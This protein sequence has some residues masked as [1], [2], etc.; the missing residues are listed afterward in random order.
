MTSP[1]NDDLNSLDSLA[2][3]NAAAITADATSNGS[4]GD[5]FT[6]A[7]IPF[8]SS[9]ISLGNSYT[10]T[11]SNTYAQMLNLAPTDTGWGVGTFNTYLATYQY[12]YKTFT[13]WSDFEQGFY[14][15]VQQRATLQGVNITGMDQAALYK[16]FAQD[17]ATVF[18]I[19]IN[20]DGTLD[21]TTGDWSVLT[22]NSSSAL[23]D[24][25]NPNNPFILAFN[26]FVNTM[27]PSDYPKSTLPSNTNFA[28]MSSFMASFQTFLTTNTS[29]NPAVSTLA[30]L[31]TGAAAI[32]STAPN[33]TAFDNVGTYEQIYNA[34][35]KNPTPA[36]F[37][38]FINAFYN[39]EIKLKG[40]FTPGD[41]ATDFLNAAQNND[42]LNVQLDEM[43]GSSISGTGSEALLVL[44]RVLELLI[45]LVQSLQN[46]GIVQA[47]RLTYYTNFQN[48]Y[49]GMISEVPV[50][51][52]GQQLT[53]INPNGTTSQFASPIGKT[54]S[55]STDAGNARNDINSAFNGLMTDNIRSLRDIQENN[56]KQ[57]QSNINTTNDAVNQ[58]TD[59]VSTFLQQ[60]STMLSSILK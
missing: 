49:T 27:T 47:Q 23:F 30:L 44:N 22:Q 19:Q 38:T 17:F 56:A 39:N 11:P 60:L 5:G 37:S 16:G 28:D 55:K 51:T 21:G 7:D 2:A 13:N 9:A 57:L 10:A 31:Q 29:T 1:I 50:F 58:Q 48:A 46:V 33:Q 8:S 41:S 42:P 20:S 25:S 54:G 45:K 6:L 26:Q 53:R 36:G 40:Y 24:E 35:A 15:Y 4:G 59:M 14:T 12:P 34:Y 43:P 52:A 3:L 32:N 18:G